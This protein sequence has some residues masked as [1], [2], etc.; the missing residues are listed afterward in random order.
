[1]KPALYCPQGVQQSQGRHGGAAHLVSGLLVAHRAL[2]S[3]GLLPKRYDCNLCL[4]RAHALVAEELD[5]SYLLSE[6]SLVPAN[7]HMLPPCI[8]YPLTGQ[9]PP[10]SSLAWHACSLR[11]HNVLT[12]LSFGVKLLYEERHTCVNGKGDSAQPVLLCAAV[13]LVAELAVLQG[14]TWATS[15]PRSTLWQPTWAW[16]WPR[17]RDPRAFARG[18]TSALM[19]L[20]RLWPQPERPSRHSSCSRRR[21]CICCK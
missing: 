15:T 4:L 1:M 3:S 14:T 18:H 2:R 21:T 9:P 16:P 20:R 19:L 12:S 5:G 6:L 8:H 10:R 13:R 17:R 7:G 11:R